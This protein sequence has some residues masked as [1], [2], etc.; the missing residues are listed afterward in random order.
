MRNEYDVSN[1]E[2]YKEN[3]DAQKREN[4]LPADLASADRR[5]S[6]RVKR[7]VCPAKDSEASALD[8]GTARA[9]LDGQA[10]QDLIGIVIEGD[11]AIRQLNVLQD[12]AEI[13]TK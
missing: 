8:N 13:V 2:L 6:V 4:R 7:P 9:E 1:A 12:W 10:A 11:Q 5:L 3:R